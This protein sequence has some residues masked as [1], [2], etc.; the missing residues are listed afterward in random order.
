MTK[1]GQDFVM[2]AG[3]NKKI[4][5]EVVDENGELVNLA[6]TEIDWVLQGNV[7]LSTASI[8]KSSTMSG[9]IV[10]ESVGTFSITLT[11]S[12]TE[13]LSGRFYHEAQIIDADG[14][15]STVMV[16]TA[17]IKKSALKKK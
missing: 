7:A 2:Y 9:E 14:D 12:D 1:E 4:Y 10:T 15:I 6:G 16:G 8:S 11:S 5:V 17:N 13:S 3:D